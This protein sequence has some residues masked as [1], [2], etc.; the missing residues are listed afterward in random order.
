M[1]DGEV[2]VLKNAEVERQLL[3]DTVEKIDYLNKL[4][5]AKSHSLMTAITENKLPA[6]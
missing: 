5:T 2:G 6:L 3:A 1:P 4:T